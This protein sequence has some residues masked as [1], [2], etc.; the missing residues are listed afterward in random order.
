[1]I[2]HIESNLAKP[3]FEIAYMTNPKLSREEIA[4]RGKKLYSESIRA[5]V[6]TAENIGKIISINVE[7][8]DYEIGDDLVAPSLRLQNKYAD[9]AIWAERIGF[10]AVY[11]VGGTL[12]RTTQ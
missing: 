3:P 9:A 7:T 11:A 6:E 5:Q 12:V 8:G 4:R 10:D 2:Y 1:M